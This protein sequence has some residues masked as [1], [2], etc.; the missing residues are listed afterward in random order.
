MSGNQKRNGAAVFKKWSA[1]RL[2]LYQVLKRRDF[3]IYLHL[4]KIGYVAGPIYS[5]PEG[6]TC[7]LAA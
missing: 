4:A 3:F 7:V 5:R 6:P 2:F 1:L